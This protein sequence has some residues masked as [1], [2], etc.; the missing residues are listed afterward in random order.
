MGVQQTVCTQG[1]RRRLV[2][3]HTVARWQAEVPA[4]KAPAHRCLC[5]RC[6][7]RRET[8]WACAAASAAGWRWLA[9]RSPATEPPAATWPATSRVTPP[10]GARCCSLGAGRGTASQE[11]AAGRRRPAQP[12]AGVR[13]AC[14]GSP[15]ALDRQWRLCGG[16]VLTS[17]RARGGASHLV[18][19]SGGGGAVHLFSA[20]AA[21]VCTGRLSAG[22]QVR[23]GAATLA[24]RATGLVPSVGAAAESGKTNSG[25][26]YHRTPAGPTD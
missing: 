15:A 1:G 24:R 25:R 12:R 21:S 4:Q 16:W 7:S 6:A 17:A 10:A 19:G 18:A 2:Q 5:Q 11:Q 20:R 26:E 8:R 14:S 9:R 22:V 13:A 23:R 3:R